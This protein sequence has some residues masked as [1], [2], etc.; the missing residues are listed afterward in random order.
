MSYKLL[1]SQQKNAVSVTRVHLQR[2]LLNWKLLIVWG[3][4][5]FVLDCGEDEGGD[6]V[7]SVFAKGDELVAELWEERQGD[8]GATN[9]G[10]VY[11]RVTFFDGIDARF[12]CLDGG[13]AEFFVE[14]SASYSVEPARADKRG[15]GKL[16]VGFLQKK[17]VEA[18][19]LIHKR[20]KRLARLF[21]QLYNL[22]RFAMRGADIVEYHR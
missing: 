12:E 16:A 8:C 13:D 22:G 5:L 17:S 6:A 19:V 11:T 9:F 4:K 7:A 1:F 14:I 21:E 18:A 2:F 3:K 15:C 20:K 10:K